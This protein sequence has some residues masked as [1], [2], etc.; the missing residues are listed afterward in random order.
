[1]TAAI[2]AY[3]DPELKRLICKEADAANLPLSEFVVKVL[4]EHLHRP[5]LAKV[6]RGKMGRPRKEITSRS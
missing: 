3:G 2:T 4:A 1:M 5:D 6:P